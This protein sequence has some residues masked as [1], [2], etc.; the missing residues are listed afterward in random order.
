M[1]AVYAT[2]LLHVAVE[3]TGAVYGV[4]EIQEKRVKN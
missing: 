1:L 2:E 4:R 3:L